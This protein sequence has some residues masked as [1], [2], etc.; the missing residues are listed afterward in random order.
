MRVHR[1]TAA[2]LIGLMALVATVPACG[3][4]NKPVALVGQTGLGI[5]D[6]IGQLQ[7]ATKGLTDAGIVPT[8]TAI[9]IQEKLLSVNEKLRPLPA[10]LRTIDTLT[11]AGS[12]ATG[13]VD[14]AI[15]ILTIVSS[16]LSVTVA[17]VPLAP[18][19]DGLLK[20]VRAAQTAIAT[21][22]VEVAKLKGGTQ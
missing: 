21:T 12:D 5:A 22:L 15:T 7:V 3:G 2:L 4:K 16:D 14:E 8:P 1:R 19:A 9:A 17:G 11:T 18:A 10:L 13:K 6:T 20:L